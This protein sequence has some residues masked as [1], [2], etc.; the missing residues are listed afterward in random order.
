MT[1]E[2]CRATERV[3][4]RPSKVTRTF[5]PPTEQKR[6]AYNP[7]T[8]RRRLKKFVRTSLGE[9]RV[10]EEGRFDNASKSEPAERKEGHR[11]CCTADKSSATRGWSLDL[12]AFYRSR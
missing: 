2:G 10:E 5:D 9:S 6:G 12:E 11:L 3:S 1:M 8:R 4:Q 7:P